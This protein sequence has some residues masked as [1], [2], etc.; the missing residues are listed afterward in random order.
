MSHGGWEKKNRKRAGQDGK[1]NLS[2]L[3]IAPHTLSFFSII[4]IFTGITSG[5]LSGGERVPG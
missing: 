1:L 3:P 2:P 4:A 5:N